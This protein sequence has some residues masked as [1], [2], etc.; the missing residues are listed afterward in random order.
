MNGTMGVM[1]PQNYNGNVLLPDGVSVP[2][3]EGV[4]EFDG[5]KYFVE[6]EDDE[7]IVSDEDENVIGKVRNGKL[8]PSGG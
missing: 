8:V 2:V 1:I 7:Y 3:R 4:A 6:N 5:K